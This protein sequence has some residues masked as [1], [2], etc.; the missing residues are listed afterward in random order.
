M[1]SLNSSA[2]KELGVAFPFLKPENTRFLFPHDLFLFLP[3]FQLLVHSYFLVL[4]IIRYPLLPD[5][6]LDLA[7]LLHYL[8]LGIE[9]AAEGVLVLEF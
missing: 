1:P 2:M 6:L 5:P 4:Y 9:D 7:H 8:F 3:I